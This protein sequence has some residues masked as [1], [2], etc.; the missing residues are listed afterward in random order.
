M[1]QRALTEFERVEAERVFL[2]SV[3]LDAVRIL[4]SD[5]LAL[6]IE[7]IGSR[8][9]RRAPRD[10]NAVTFGRLIRFSRA[11]K[12][13]EGSSERERIDDMAWMIHELTHV[14]QY[15]HFGWVYLPQAI[16]AQIR[17]GPSAYQYS[18]MTS[19]ADRGT[20]LEDMW[21][22]GKRLA[23]F[24]R[25]Q[26]GDIARDYYKGLKKEL[27]TSGWLHFIEEIRSVS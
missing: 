16:G 7:T 3:D 14:W 5:W 15:Q 20:D 21:Q 2:T 11:L 13:G 12:L 24:N 8:F 1:P 6:K 10:T 23:D 19:L 25:E 17:E 26:Q 18:D 27:N 22:A 4:E 9:A